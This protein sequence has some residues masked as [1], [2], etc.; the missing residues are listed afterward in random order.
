MLN[1]KK[2]LFNAIMSHPDDKHLVMTNDTDGF[3]TSTYVSEKTG[4]PI[5]GFFLNF[6]KLIC[7]PV[8]CAFRKTPVY[9]DCDV[10]NH[11]NIAN[12]VSGIGAMG[13][14]NLNQ[15]I[16][17]HNYQEKYAGSSYIFAR[18]LC[19]DDLNS[20]P[21]KEL[22]FMALIDSHFKQFFDYKRQWNYWSKLLGL[23]AMTRLLGSHD[24][25]Y[26]IKMH[27]RYN[28]GGQFWLDDTGRIQTD[29]NIDMIRDE[30]SVD[31]HLPDTEFTRVPLNGNFRTDVKLIK[32]VSRKKLDYYRKKV[33][34]P[35]LSV[36][37]P[38]ELSTMYCCALVYQYIIRY[39]IPEFQNAR[40]MHID[41]NQPNAQNQIDVID[42]INNVQDAKIRHYYQNQ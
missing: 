23:E 35:Y 32:R 2:E 12:H 17:F 3:M 28:M 34:R 37:T 13:A 39:S 7:N 42:R 16:S 20:L 10:I 22:L 1:T 31:I 30:L 21:E 41:E 24:K 27:R 29:I 18:V 8:I 15:G 14:F 5:G 19:G 9:M 40:V 33:K 26:F 38:D 36:I 6:E 11:M 25:D 4:I